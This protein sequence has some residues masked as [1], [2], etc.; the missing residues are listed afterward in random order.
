MIKEDVAGWLQEHGIVEVEAMFPDLSG[1]CRGK[2][3]P[4]EKFVLD[5]VK[6][7][8][9]VAVQS[10]T[11]DWGHQVDYINEQDNDMQL[12]PDISSCFVIPWA[13]ADEPAAQLICDCYSIRNR[14]VQHIPRYILKKVMG[15][16][17]RSGWTP[18]V[19]PEI[20]FYFVKHDT[21]PDNPIKPPVGHTGWP[22]GGQQP[23]SIDGVNEYEKIVNDIYMF[24]EEAGLDIDTLNSEEG[25]AQMEINFKHGCP[26]AMADQ[27]LIFKR[28]VREAALR[29]GVRATFMA[30]PIGDQPG[31]SL[32][33]HQSVVDRNGA[34]LFSTASGGNSPLMM[35]Y[36][37]GLQAHAGECQLI[38]MPTINSYRRGNIE[39]STINNQWG[40]NNRTVG[41]RIP[42]TDS[43]DAKRIENR[44]P[45]ADVNPYLAIAASLLS[46]YHGMTNRIKPGTECRGL[47]WDM[48]SGLHSGLEG[49]I[50][51]MQKSSMLRT[52][53]GSAFVNLFTS[54]K[55]TEFENYR[56]VVSSWERMYLLQTA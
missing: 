39:H 27:V 25:I 35:A 33:I 9:S 17:R 6:L 30:K 24:A 51:S 20:E 47:G 3:V 34:S 43:P 44:I 23:Y 14:P 2:I 28:C 37:G 12:V 4:T 15:M 40:V 45:G 49:C 26:L 1:I 16:Y 11:G 46:G 29:H 53:L 36:L 7:P 38:Y 41:F 19:A 56:R 18:V 50:S 5:L 13:P 48:P 54:V 10:L 42:E 55:Q 32:H 52:M 31:S 21:N 22:A 8:E